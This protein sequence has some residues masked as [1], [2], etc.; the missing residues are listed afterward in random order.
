[1]AGKIAN[2]VIRFPLMRRKK[3]VVT[4]VGIFLANAMI[5]SISRKSEKNA[6]GWSRWTDVTRR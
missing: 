2:P 4:I 1:V 3:R 6:V 5:L